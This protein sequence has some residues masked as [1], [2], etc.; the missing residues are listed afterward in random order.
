MIGS[1]LKIEHG[2]YRFRHPLALTVRSLQPVILRLALPT[3]SACRCLLVILLPLFFALLA[4]SASP[5]S[6][7]FPRLPPLAFFS[8]TFCSFSSLLGP[9]RAWCEKFTIVCRGT[10]IA[11]AF[12]RTAVRAIKS[13]PGIATESP[14]VDT[15]EVEV[16]R[17]VSRA[18]LHGGKRNYDYQRQKL[19]LSDCETSPHLRLLCRDLLV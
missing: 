11:P 3:I 15:Q 10:A 16:A 18:T 19:Q 6:L 17:G 8:F 14:G 7:H 9:F 12:L 5:L 13:S 4:S 1:P 2:S